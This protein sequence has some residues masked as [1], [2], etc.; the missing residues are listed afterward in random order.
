MRILVLGG[1]G[2]I[3]RRVVRALLSDGDSVTILTRDSRR[4][5]APEALGAKVRLG[6]LSDRESL[7]GPIRETDLIVN[8]AFPGFLGRMSRRRAERDALDGLR[9]M[10]NLLAAVSEVGDIPLILTEGTMACGD[11]G[12]GWIDETSPCT[13]DRGHG[14]L[15]R[16]SVPYARRV[17]KELGL[18]TV[19]MSISG[20]YG[21]GSWFRESVYAFIA[22]NQGMVVGDGRNVWSFVHVDDV[23]EAYRLAVRKLPTGR[24]IPLA[25]DE[26]IPYVQFANEVADRLGKRRVRHMPAWPAR[27]LLGSVLCEA[28]TMTQRVSNASAREALGWM[29]R[30]ATFREGIAATL[31][32][33]QLE[34]TAPMAR[35]AAPAAPTGMRT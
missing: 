18:R 14:R 8:C 22:R 11:S 13:F 9:Q 23:A 21:P 27:V 4:A 16:Y 25:D 32:A 7:V 6:D 30:H 20:A 34:T 33:I 10:Q 1:T 12:D 35:P 15:L 28:L 3:G 5:T 2:F 17:T 24:T 29:P 26:P 31:A 19:T